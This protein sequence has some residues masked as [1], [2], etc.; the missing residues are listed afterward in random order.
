MNGDLDLL[1][2]LV[3]ND[4]VDLMVEVVVMEAL[5]ADAFDFDFSSMDTGASLV[6]VSPG[7]MKRWVTLL[8]K[9]PFGNTEKMVGGSSPGNSDKT[10]INFHL[11]HCLT[12]AMLAILK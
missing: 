11:S 7:R 12:D 8:L 5:S 10:L 9:I 6:L 4:A 2:L 1:N 3:I